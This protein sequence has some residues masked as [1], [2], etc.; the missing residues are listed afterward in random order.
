M[1]CVM[2][3]Y[4]LLQKENER[5]WDFLTANPVRFSEQDYAYWEDEENNKLEILEDI[6]HV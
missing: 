6:E 4:E 3:F 2:N 5:F 1:R